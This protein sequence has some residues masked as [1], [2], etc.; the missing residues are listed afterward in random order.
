MTDDSP[1]IAAAERLEAEALASAT[2]AAPPAVAAELGL[3]LLAEHGAVATFASAVDALA[4]NRVVGLG[5]G[6]PT[7]ETE[8]DRI[9]DVARQRG[10]RRLFVQVA[11]TAEPAE[12]A[13][14]LQ[15]RGGQAYNRW[16]RLWRPTSAPLPATALT[17]LEIHRVDATRAADLARVVRT[18]FG[19]PPAVDPWLAA[20]VGRPGWAHYAAI[21]GGEVV[22]TAALFTT[23]GLAWLGFAA[24]LPSHRGHGAQS[25][26][27]VHRL[28][29]AVELGCAWAV[30]ETAEDL[31]D[32]PAP[33]YRNMRRLGFEEAYRR[34]NYLVV[35]RRD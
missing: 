10:V 9:L 11:P 24:T 25:A 6:T 29:R 13:A 18:A 33:S 7:S 4:L 1:R 16:V 17:E 19:M 32:R 3:T 34:L 2:L 28:R 14:W 22:A 8:I 15:A 30:T 27:I 31:S 20:M 12:L 26:L 35:L 21:E 5:V 23:G